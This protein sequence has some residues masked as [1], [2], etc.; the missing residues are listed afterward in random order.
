MTITVQEAMA[1]AQQAGFTGQS[2]STIVAIAEAESNLN[3]TARGINTNGSID[4]GILQINNVYHSEVPD[5]C[6]YDPTCSFQQAYRIS[7]AGTN[8][9]PWTTYN[10][11]AYQQYLT[12]LMNLTLNTSPDSSSSSGGS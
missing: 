2:A 8:F 7:D 4:R 5:S 11:G 6:A 9:T 12:S 1:D 10:S 3:P